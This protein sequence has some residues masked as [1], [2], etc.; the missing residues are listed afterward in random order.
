MSDMDSVSREAEAERL[1]WTMKPDD[2]AALAQVDIHSWPGAVQSDVLFYQSNSVL[3]VPNEAAGACWTV[4]AVMMLKDE[5][6]IIWLNLNWLYFI[7]FRRFVLLD[8]NSNDNTRSEIMRFRQARSDVELLVLDDPI[9]RYMQAQK[10]TALFRTA[11]SIWP[12]LKWIF[13]IDADEFLIPQRGMNVLSN[14]DPKVHAITIPKTQHFR[15][16]MEDEGKILTLSAMPSRGPLCRVPPKLVPRSA[17]ELSIGQGNHKLTRIDHGQVIYAGGFQHGFY[18]REFPYRSCRQFISKV[19][20]GGPAIL[21]A[22]EYFGGSIG[23]NH[24]LRFYRAYLTG[25][26]AEL[27]ALYRANYIMSSQDFVHDPFS[28]APDVA[29]RTPS[30][31]PRF[32]ACQTAAQKTAAIGDRKKLFYRELRRRWNVRDHANEYFDCRSLPNSLPLRTALE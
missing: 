15:T 17:V 13:P 4:A 6:D 31:D 11:N 18:Y 29:E 2:L 12:D 30:S 10:T 3:G 32:L 5:E 23:G 1:I 8:N 22:E 25:G 19:C 14:I 27:E 20:N 24:W 16:A 9:V 28:G 7:G 26:S 21:A